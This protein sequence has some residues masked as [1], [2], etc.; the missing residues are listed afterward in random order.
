MDA[1]TNDFG[2]RKVSLLTLVFRTLA[3]L[4]GGVMGTAV[5]LFAVFLGSSVLSSISGDGETAALNPLVIFIFM[6]V[7]FLSSCL[8]N[9]ISAL[10]IQLTD[11]EKYKMI[12]SA[13]YQVFVANL[14]L[15]IS[16]VPVYIIVS[17]VSIEMMVYV[18]AIQILISVMASALILEILSDAK[19]ALL[20]VYSMIFGL[21][22][23][24]AVNFALYQLAGQNGAVL[25]FAA[26][27]VIWMMVGLFNGLTGMAYRFVYESY[28]VD[29]LSKYVK[30]G[31]DTEPV[32][33][34]PITEKDVLKMKKDDSGSEFLEKEEEPK[35]P[36][37]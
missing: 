12:S 22:A 5:L 24:S 1:T 14:V 20:G 21:L 35:E 32:T 31:Q 19:Y 29:F 6:A 13:V 17:G 3:G 9:C 16:T 2:P 27:P 7:V 37:A 8:S 30:Y 36:V 34:E 18:A 28:G 23:A 10:L 25:L 4:G 11:R 15:F 26:L 33:E